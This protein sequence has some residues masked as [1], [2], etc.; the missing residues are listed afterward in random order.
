M[1][2]KLTRVIVATAKDGPTKESN[3]KALAREALLLIK[4]WLQLDQD[5]APHIKHHLVDLED[6][7]AQLLDQ[8]DRILELKPSI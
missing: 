4:T 8:A 5:L 3:R 7:L 6:S 1:L 2:G